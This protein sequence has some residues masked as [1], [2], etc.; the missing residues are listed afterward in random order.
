MS[1]EKSIFIAEKPVFQRISEKKGLFIY[2][3]VTNPMR[4]WLDCCHVRE[5]WTSKFRYF[6]TYFLYWGRNLCFACFIW[7][8]F[9]M[10]CTPLRR[11]PLRMNGER[12]TPFVALCNIFST[13]PK[14]TRRVEQKSSGLEWL[15][16]TNQGYSGLVPIFAGS[17]I[18]ALRGRK[19]R[20]FLR[21]SAKARRE[22]R[23]AFF[24]A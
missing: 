22:T 23:V 18:S 11:Q 6:L 8:K 10:H 24:L 12:G 16:Q 21:Y 9:C 1:A 14:S 7:M 17:F 3:A 20:H 15:Q 4:Q 2:A 5:T 13:V 19:M